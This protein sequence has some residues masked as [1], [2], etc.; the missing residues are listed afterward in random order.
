MLRSLSVIAGYV[1]VF[2]ATAL[3]G[4]WSI[5][6]GILLGLDPLG[7]YIAAVGASALVMLVV[8]GKGAEVM[9]RFFPDS[10]E[11]VAASRAREFLDRWG[12]PGLAIVGSTVLG[13][14]ITLVAALVFSVDKNKFRVWYLVSSVVGLGVLVL[15]WSAVLP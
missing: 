12:V 2:L 11:K 1:L 6:L 7:V 14:T 15:F 3:I 13:P 10:G 5:P 8:L 4:G 9:H